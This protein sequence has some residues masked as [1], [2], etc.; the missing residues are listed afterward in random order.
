MKARVIALY[1]PQYHPTPENDI[2]W[3]EGFTEWTNVAR[4]TKLY[5][6]HYQPKI[7][8]ALG[9]YDLRL[10]EVRERQAELA[11]RAG[12]EAFC[13]YR[14]WF[15]E[16]KESLQRPFEEVVASGHPD[17]PF[18]VCWA[19]HSW[20]KKAWDR[21]N[22]GKDV[23]LAEQKYP[24]KEDYKAHFMSLLT[25]FKDHRYVKV[26]GKL[27]FMILNE[28]DGC[29]EFMSYWQELAAE[30]GLPGFHFVTYALGVKRIQHKLNLGFDAVNVQRLSDYAAIDP[31]VR[32]R[33]KR[34]VN[35]HVFNRPSVYPYGKAINYLV[36]EEDSLTGVYPTI[37]PNWDHTPRSGNKGYLLEK[38]EPE[39]F[40]KHC[41]MVFDE[42]KDKPEEDRVVFLKSWNEWGEGN[43]MEPD[44]RY[45]Y[46]YI[47]ALKRALT[48]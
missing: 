35:F 33:L 40:E 20:Y 15:G 32:I 13:Y 43:Y 47:D 17:F 11:R 16:G 9:F 45:G 1:L 46:G 27:L 5:R 34:W 7:P 23:L 14:Y 42:I 21:N 10:P 8:T 29:K 36:G 25:A 4:A 26:H 3:G 24:G 2:W 18:C 12:V 39:L 37:V 41:R 6:N 22:P 44:L 38:C 31:D 28:Y 19:N 30:H 48:E